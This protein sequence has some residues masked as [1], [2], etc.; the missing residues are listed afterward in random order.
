MVK[1]GE[2]PRGFHRISMKIPSH[3]LGTCQAELSQTGEAVAQ[4]AALEAERLKAVE[5]A[6][7]EARRPISDENHSEFSRF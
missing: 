1:N 2:N 3:R 6:Q 4:A 5:E 7:A